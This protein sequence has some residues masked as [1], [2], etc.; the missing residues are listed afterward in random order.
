MSTLRQQL[1]N[2]FLTPSLW[3]PTKPMRLSGD[4][5]NHFAAADTNRHSRPLSFRS[6]MGSPSLPPQCDLLRSKDMY[7]RYA[8][9]TH[10]TACIPMA[11]MTPVSTSLSR[12]QGGCTGKENVISGSRSPK[13]FSSKSSPVSHMILTASTFTPPSV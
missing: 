8:P 5:T 12:V 7:R 1:T 3:Q 11:S 9:I 10:A 13:I 6:P 2:Y 4:P